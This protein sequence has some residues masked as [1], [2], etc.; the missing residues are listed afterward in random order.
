MIDET[1]DREAVVRN[2]QDAGCPREFIERFL[3]VMEH[4]TKAEQLSL[5]ACQ[6]CRLLRQIHAQQQKLDCLDFL[7][8]ALQRKADR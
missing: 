2:L 1:M 5:L 4:G 8:D 3:D 7:R 6:R